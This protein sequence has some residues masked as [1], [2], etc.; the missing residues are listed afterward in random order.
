VISARS[1]GS[2]VP[3]PGNEPRHGVRVVISQRRSTNGLSKRSGAARPR[4]RRPLVHRKAQEMVIGIGEH[5]LPVAVVDRVLAMPALL[6]RDRPWKAA[7]H[8]PLIEHVAI[9]DP[10]LKIEP[11]NIGVGEWHVGEV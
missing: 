4:W 5:E 9:R 6:K 1:H 7:G 2:L 11:T 8:D 3:E 10:D